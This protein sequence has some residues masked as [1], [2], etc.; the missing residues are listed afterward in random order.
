MTYE[1]RTYVA[2]ADRR[3][4]MVERVRTVSAEVFKD[5][6]ITPVA[7][8]YPVGEADTL[9]YLIRHEGDPDANWAAFMADQRWIDARAASTF[10]VTVT[11]QRLELTD[12]SPE[13]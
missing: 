3:D 12:F 9:V 4:D 11:A 5:C 1:L 2:S 13:L 10:T 7:Y 6:G 8:W